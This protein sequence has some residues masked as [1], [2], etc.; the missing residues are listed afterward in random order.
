M[1]S[2][3]G[4]PRRRDRRGGDA[5]QVSSE[6]ERPLR[7]TRVRGAHGAAPI[8]LGSDQIEKGS[9]AGHA[10]KKEKGGAGAGGW[11]GRPAHGIYDLL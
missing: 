10:I 11:E 3:T 6:L 8:R 2:C 4:H 5:S 1:R 7:R 9:S